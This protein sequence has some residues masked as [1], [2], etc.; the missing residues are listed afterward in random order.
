MIV[1]GAQDL[2]TEQL[3]AEDLNLFVPPVALTD[4]PVDVKIRYRHA[5]APA[6]VH[7]LGDGRIHVRFAEPQR[8]V[9]PG[10]SC[11]VYRDGWVLAGGRIAPQEAFP[12]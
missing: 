5:A 10:Q 1:G 3:V 8:A 4:G 6:R 2:F 11:V 12:A 9:A 7:W